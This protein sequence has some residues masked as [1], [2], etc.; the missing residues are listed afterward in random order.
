MSSVASLESL[1]ASD[2]QLLLTDGKDT[3]LTATI[4]STKVSCF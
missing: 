3:T 1:L 2:V 4:A